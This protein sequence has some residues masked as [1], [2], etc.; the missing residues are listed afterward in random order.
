MRVD[1]R[2][3][4][5]SNILAEVSNPNYS[6]SVG[7]NTNAN[8]FELRRFGAPLGHDAG[9]ASRESMTQLYEDYAEPVL[10]AAFSVKTIPMQRILDAP[11]FVIKKA[12]ERTLVT[13]RVFELEFEYRDSN[14]R[15]APF[16]W[17][18]VTFDLEHDW[19]VTE[20]EQLGRRSRHVGRVEY[21]E[22][23]GVFLPKKHRLWIQ[24]RD[25]T[26]VPEVPSMHHE[27]IKIDFAQVPAT[28]FLVSVFGLTEPDLAIK[29][30]SGL[31]IWAII[32][33][34]AFI[35]AICLAVSRKL[36]KA[37]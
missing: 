2:N 12:T 33:L 18:R 19:G 13:G 35:G 34:L 6:F 7:K 9:E 4:Q 24:K 25:Q 10:T 8:T 14:P 20:Y 30:R 5:S 16:E 31:S 17:A 26:E 23:N 27:I 28:Q 37:T 11:H 3:E 1:V 36:S 15:F 32:A 22:V 29:N 21:G